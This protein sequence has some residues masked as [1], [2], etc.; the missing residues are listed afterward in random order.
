MATTILP[1]PTAEIPP[2]PPERND[3]ATFLRDRHAPNYGSGSGIWLAVFAITMSFAALTSALL[4]RQGSGDWTHLVVPSLLYLNT[5]IL[6]LSSFTFE[7]SGRNMRQEAL[8]KR[9]AYP[10]ALGWLAITLF[11]GLAFVAGQYLAWQKLAAMG[12]FL[13]T[14]PNSSF[15]YVFTGLHAA[16]VLAGIIA[17]TYLVIK[18]AR[19]SGVVRRSTYASTAIYWHFMGGLWLYLLFVIRARL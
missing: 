11:L 13:A 16:H 4:V 5:G 18:L 8:I 6:I 9:S 2:A 17:L 7:L 19:T 14:N 15:F 12:L 3:P 1:P 10:Q